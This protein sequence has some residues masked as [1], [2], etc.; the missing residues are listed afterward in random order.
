MSAPRTCRERRVEHTPDRARVV[1]ARCYWD[2]LLHPGAEAHLEDRELDALVPGA[3][4]PDA[5]TVQVLHHLHVSLQL[6]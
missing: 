3:E 2:R 5:L 1:S 6:Q 4:Q